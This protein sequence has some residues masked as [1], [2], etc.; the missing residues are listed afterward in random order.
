MS[1]AVLT[2]A[3]IS[4]IIFRH[5]GEGHKCRQ[6]AMGAEPANDEPKLMAKE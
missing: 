4:A 6:L 5:G 2:S 3:L 1:A